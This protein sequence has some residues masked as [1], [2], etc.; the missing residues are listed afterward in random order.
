[1]LRFS[2]LIVRSSPFHRLIARSIQL[3]LRCDALLVRLSAPACGRRFKPKAYCSQR[4]LP[5]AKAWWRYSVYFGS[6]LF[7]QG[8]DACFSLSPFSHLRTFR[9]HCFLKRRRSTFSIQFP[10]LLFYSSSPLLFFFFFHNQKKRSDHMRS[11]LR[12]SP[13]RD[14]TSCLPARSRYTHTLCFCLVSYL[15]LSLVL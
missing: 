14:A 13:L 8:S 7:G 11:C 1:M 10:S 2:S 9:N 4:C 6:T 15:L 5:P 3:C 12:P